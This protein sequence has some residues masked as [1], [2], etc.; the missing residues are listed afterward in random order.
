MMYYDGHYSY[1][2]SYSFHPLW[3]IHLYIAASYDNHKD[4]TPR[5]KQL[6]RLTVQRVFRYTIKSWRH[7]HMMDYDGHYFC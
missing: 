4:S 6:L 7:G 5:Q 3:A 1:K 2:P